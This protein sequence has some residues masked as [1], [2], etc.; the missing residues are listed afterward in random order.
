MDKTY[1]SSVKSSCGSA[2]T[3]ARLVLT[4]EIAEFDR[5]RSWFQEFAR[6]V[7]L[8]EEITS[9]MLIAADEVFTNIAAYAYPGAAG[10]VEVSAEQKAAMLCLTFKDTG[11]PFDPTKS[12]DPDIQAPAAERPI[13]GLGIFVMK[14][15]MDQVEYR[16]ENG[17]NI[18][19][20]SKRIFPEVPQ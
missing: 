18:L 12:A 4:T 15:L 2:G 17:C 5:L 3:A 14:K 6:Q 16:R 11:K 8:P 13:G 19:T 1:N 9:R 20:L 10:Q 7:E